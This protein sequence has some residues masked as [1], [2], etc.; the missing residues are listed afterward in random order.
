MD[1]ANGGR[2][3]I[4]A[5]AAWAGTTPRAV[6]HYHRTGVL[7]EPA[8]TSGGYRSYD[9]ADLARLLRVRRLV[10]LGLPLARVAE[11]LTDGDAPDRLRDV[12]QALDADLERQELEVRA[13]RRSIR[14]LLDGDRGNAA[15]EVDRLRADLVRALGGV[16]AVQRELDVLEVIAHEAPEAVPDMVAAYRRILDD[17]G[18]RGLS[19]RTSELFERLGA[20]DLA[21]GPVADLEE[22]L[23]QALADLLRHALDG[24]GHPGDPAAADGP[25][26]ALEQLAVGTLTPAQRRAVERARDLLVADG[27]TGGE[28]ADAGVAR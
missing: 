3:T 21:G 20:G 8:R 16:P 10:A 14:V 13:R 19:A 24:A 22:E 5:L 15:A 23:A 2:L 6:R 11:V 26:S 12:L 25:H 28:G 27:G 1:D 7:P 17:D 18:A 9:L 4:G